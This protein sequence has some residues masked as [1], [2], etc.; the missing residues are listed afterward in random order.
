MFSVRTRITA[1]PPG[2]KPTGPYSGT[3]FPPWMSSE[4]TSIRPSGEGKNLCVRLDC[5]QAYAAGSFSANTSVFSI[6]GG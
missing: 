4:K 5:R 6:T 2:T 3:R 1:R